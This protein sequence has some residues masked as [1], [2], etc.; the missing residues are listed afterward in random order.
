MT[1]EIKAQEFM[2]IE[3]KILDLVQKY[4]FLKKTRFFIFKI[5]YA[6]CCYDEKEMVAAIKNLLKFTLR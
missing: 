1:P 4:Y 3:N 5:H 6:G 2:D